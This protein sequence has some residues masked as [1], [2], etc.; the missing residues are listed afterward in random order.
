MH[1]QLL[2]PPLWIY[3]LPAASAQFP[4]T[5]VSSQ[6][7][8]ISL[9]T[10]SSN[11][12]AADAAIMS[13]TQTEALLIAKS[14]GGDGGAAAAESG[15]R[16]PA[17]DWRRHRTALPHNGRHRRGKCS[18]LLDKALLW[19]LTSLETSK[20]CKA[21]GSGAAGGG[22]GGEGAASTATPIPR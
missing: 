8:S 1:L 21:N 10:F 18:H 4:L 12:I 3:Q 20:L 19:S 2:R 22:G 5:G 9:P 15:A 14:G 16:R 11:H 13:Q 7:W 17:T 6:P